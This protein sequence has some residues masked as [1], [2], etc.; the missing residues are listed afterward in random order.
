MYSRAFP[1]AYSSVRHS[2]GSTR[3]KVPSF[4]KDTHI[5]R[6]NHRAHPS[7][8][9][10]RSTTTISPPS[11]LLQAFTRKSGT[12]EK[13]NTYCRGRSIG[14]SLPSRE[15][16]R[17]CTPKSTKPTRCRTFW[18]PSRGSPMRCCSQFSK[19]RWRVRIRGRNNVQSVLSPKFPVDG[20]TS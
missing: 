14:Y 4:L 3:I 9:T 13:P 8:S 5:F 1:T 6:T 19:R 18:R 2:V 10:Q 7:W 16:K 20:E 11:K 15:Y 17:R 12:S